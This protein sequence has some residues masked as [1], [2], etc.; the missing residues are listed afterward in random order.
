MLLQFALSS[1]AIVLVLA[2]IGA[3]ALSRVATREA[4]DEARAVTAALVRSTIGPAITDAAVRG[5]REAL[6]ELDRTVRERVLYGPTVRVKV[7]AR[8]GRILYS[9]AT[10]LIGERY[11]LRPD[12]S[13]ALRGGTTHA[14][15]TEHARRENRFERGKGKL[16]EVYMP[17]TTAGASAWSSRRTAARAPSP[18]RAEAFSA[19]SSPLCSSC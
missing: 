11:A 15:V 5:D 10:A 4:L 14:D 17:Y 6:A 2:T 19:R 3:V 13:A 7:W 1:F 8:D 12:L 9:D 16:V 18:P